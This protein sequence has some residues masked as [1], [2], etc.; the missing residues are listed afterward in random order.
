MINE[1]AG[2][3]EWDITKKKYISSSLCTQKL[4]EQYRKV[5]STWRLWTHH[6]TVLQFHWH[7]AYNTQ[8]HIKYCDANSIN[9]VH[10]T[11][12]SHWLYALHTGSVQDVSD[13]QK[14]HLSALWCCCILSPER[15]A[16]NLMNAS[17]PYAIMAK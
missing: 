14:K 13:R 1:T 11:L 12:S 7:S 5:Y 9:I 3:S 15:R 16:P 10:N 17:Y 4:Q 6:K 2:L 8:Y